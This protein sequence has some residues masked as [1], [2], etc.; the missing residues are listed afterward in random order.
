MYAK[1]DPSKIGSYRRSLAVA[2]EYAKRLLNARKVANADKIAEKLV[3]KYPSHDFII[4]RAEAREI[5]LPVVNLDLKQDEAFVDIVRSVVLSGESIYAFAKANEKKR[6]TPTK[7]RVASKG[8][9]AAGDA[10]KLKAA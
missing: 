6:K 3:W 2:E 10:A 1:I 8:P 7:R 4:D 5:G 9:A